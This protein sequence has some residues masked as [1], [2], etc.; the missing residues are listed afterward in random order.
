M[1][2]RT[3]YGMFETNSSSSHSISFAGGFK[4]QDSPELS[5]CLLTAMKYGVKPLTLIFG[6]RAFGTEHNG[7][8][9]M[10]LA[11]PEAKID[12]ILSNIYECYCSEIDFINRQF[13]KHEELDLSPDRLTK[14]MIDFS[15]TCDWKMTEKAQDEYNQ[16]YN[17]LKA[18]LNKLKAA[19]TLYCPCS[20]IE[21]IQPRDQESAITKYTEMGPLIHEINRMSVEDLADFIWNPNSMIHLMNG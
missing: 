1:T 20:D 11:N 18:I 14:E 16:R 15:G 4:L 5:Q 9:E 17:Q 10:D 12:F 8:K 7:N 2:K 3:R 6:N 13:S 21:I 19:I